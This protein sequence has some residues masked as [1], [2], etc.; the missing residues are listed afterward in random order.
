MDQ[1]ETSVTISTSIAIISGVLL[2][3][4][5]T[6]PFIKKLESNGIMHFLIIISKTLLNKHSLTDSE[7]ESLLPRFNPPQEFQEFQESQESQ[8]P[9]E[10]IIDTGKSDKDKD[11]DIKWLLNNKIQLSNFK[12]LI[13]KCTNTS[14][15]NSKKIEET[16]TQMKKYEEG[17]FTLLESKKIQTSEKYEI[18]YI[19]RYIRTS[20]PDK[21]M[22]M[23]SLSDNTKNTLLSLGYRLDYDSVANVSVIKW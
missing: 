22:E 15:T 2:L 12:E 18:D 20:Y 21:Q 19:I 23:R 17:F 14:I 7:S 3:L 5:E 9:Q 4:S 10:C 11:K 1:D 8:E 16:Q 6:L 13:D